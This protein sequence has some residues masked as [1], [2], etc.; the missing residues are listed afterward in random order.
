MSTALKRRLLVVERDVLAA[1][2]LCQMVMELGFEVGGIADN[3]RDAL[4][5]LSSGAYDLVL[6]EDGLRGDIDSAALAVRIRDTLRV[7]V[8][9][10][11][12]MKDLSFFHRIKESDPYGIVLKPFTALAL[13][14]QL[15]L[16]FHRWALERERERMLPGRLAAHEA[17]DAAFDAML[18]IC[19][20]CKKIPE[21]N[22]RW[23]KLEDYLGRHADV[24]F[25]HSFCPECEQKLYGAVR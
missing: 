4:E 21:H 1:R 10:V 3:A 2:A 24:Q 13:Q 12:E 14:V 19:S 23:A 11:A 16:A 9:Y 5:E 25:T 8:V 22:G 15:E 17:L 18:P 6:L 20:C 7:P